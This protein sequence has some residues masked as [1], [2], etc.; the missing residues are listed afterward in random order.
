MTPSSRQLLAR[1]QAF[2]EIAAGHLGQQRAVAWHWLRAMLD[3]EKRLLCY[4]VTAVRAWSVILHTRIKLP[5]LA[6]AA[7]LRRVTLW[8]RMFDAICMLHICSTFA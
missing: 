4:R 2:P 1:M 8:W 5:A 3:A 7:F 6:C